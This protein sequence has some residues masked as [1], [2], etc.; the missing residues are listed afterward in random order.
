M[1]IWGILRGAL[2]LA[3]ALY[4]FNATAADDTE[5]RLL[6]QPSVSKDHLAFVY[7]G[8][9]WISDR[10]GRNPSRITSHPAS[11]FAPHFSPDGN[12]IAFS[13]AYDNNIDVYVVSA[14]GG[15]PRRLTWHPAADL[16]T[17]W[18]TDGKRVLFVSDREV[19]NSRSGQLFEVPLE[20]GYERK[21]M[22]AV[23]VEGAWS[24]D[25]KRMAYRP[26]TMA[27]SGTSGW[28]QHR[29]GDTPPLWIIDPA[30]GALEKIPHVNASDRDPMWIGADIA[31][32][33]DRNDGAAN[34]F[35]Y[36]AQTHAVRQL[37]HET[38]WDVRNAGAYDHTIVYEVG[39]QLK[40]IDLNSGQIQ[41]IPVHLASQAIQA[42][43]QW[44]DVARLITS[45]RLST[46]GKR[47]LIT[48]RGDV[49]SVP[50][51]DGAVR[52]LT[53]TSGVREADA[54]WS[55]DGQR[56]AYL[57]DEGG[58]QALLI[59]DALGLEKPVRHAVA[60]ASDK[61]AYFTLLEWAPD[62]RRVVFQDNHLHLYALELKTDAVTL[63]D[64]SKRR[65]GF[66][67]TV[68]PDGQWLAY[69]LIGDNYLA[70]VKL[71]NFT[72]GQ[73]AELADKFI[74]TDDPVFGG[75]D[76]LYFTASIDAGPSR[77]ALDMST[78]ERPL[79]KAIYAAVLPADGHSPLAP[80][81]GDEELPGKGKDAQRKD[82]T[83][84]VRPAEKE[85][86]HEDEADQTHPADKGRP[87]E[88]AHPGE[89]TSA[90]VKP[91][92]IDLAGLSQ[93]FVPI[94]IA[95]R[96]YDRLIVASDGA[97]LY[98]SRKQPGSSQEPPAPLPNRGADADLYRYSF[99]DRS[100]KQ[101]RSSLVDVTASA[102]RKKLL[103][104]LG[105]NQLDIADATEKLDSKPIELN[106]LR[107][108]VDP[109]QEWQQIFDEV[110]R[111]EQAY[112][113]DPN[114]H[115]LDWRA[116][117]ARYEPL[118]KYVQRREDLTEL[119]IEMIGEMQVGHNRIGGGD[120]HLERPAGI[121]LLGAEFKVEK[122]LYRIQKIYRGDRW[123]PFLV[124]P[125][126]AAGVNIAEGDYI[127]AI[128]GHPLDATI[129]IFSLLE[130]TVDKQ[131]S[132]TVSR[133]GSTGASRT[134]TVIP[135]GSEVGLRQWDWV[136]RN[137]EYVERKSGGKIAYVYLP[138][139][140]DNGYAF[141]NRMFFAQ[142]DRDAL[143]VDDRR[144]G[145][146]QAA[147][148]ILEV[149]NRKYLSGWKDRDGLVFNTPAGAIYGPKAML[150]DQDAGSGGDYLPYTFRYLGLGK[151]VGT[152]TWGGL[153]G[154]SANPPLIDGGFLTVPYFR[155]YTPTSQWRVENEGV[156]PDLEVDLD[157]AQVNAGTDN[158][159][160]A[161]IANVLEQLQTAKTV[162]LKA[163]PPYP[164]QL[165]K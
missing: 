151:L 67:T 106:G 40:S 59:R 5:I 68:S 70:R 16:V 8:D 139:T 69:T 74:Q 62:G 130:N 1:Q 9:I 75:S 24:P 29:G 138:D 158:Q 50:V 14:S 99:E 57:S 53:A 64:T 51:K 86:K 35:L 23:A 95:E 110:W 10:D 7:A 135:T 82:D 25:G 152:R 153:I 102:D 160:D 6:R 89:K 161:A 56:V 112:F 20:G 123:N 37:T 144:N 97:L 141:F 47:V 142:V 109:H 145:G 28:R 43:P 2:A 66:K 88:K 121:G 78:Q 140:A 149:L 21:I 96:N 18:S 132:L 136:A 148:Y 163:A 159:L 81:S 114:M 115:G 101:L 90:P 52:N 34:L 22:K 154:I 76:L 77:S 108:L 94:P 116:V 129:N 107:M 31:F 124:S 104:V 119:L 146:G 103:L 44:K 32:I 157:P 155:M 91:T 165:G 131:V 39:G 100:E 93:R 164:T 137:Q 19:D 98:L 113:Y 120:I 80:K 122:G 12:W 17:G 84:A 117:R 92:R 48:A 27:Y 11:E 38:Q 125:L 36:D 134:V 72:T 41:P 105:E 143:I 45:A 3:L 55:S 42:R 133:E 156:A 85:G 4:C 147:N 73:S 58:T 61:A 83:D 162:P 118:L 13:A 79:R 26:Y 128:N 150:I 65:L 87:G 54:L 111:M 49:F 127:L 46:T 15:Q 60:R 126:T 71:F 33:S 63:V 30:S